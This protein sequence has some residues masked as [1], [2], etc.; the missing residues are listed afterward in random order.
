MRSRSPCTAG[1]HLP[2]A[3]SLYRLRA[4]ATGGMPGMV[5]T[6]GAA[7]VV[8]GTLGTPAGALGTPAGALACARTDCV[9]TPA[10]MAVSSTAAINASVVRLDTLVTGNARFM[11]LK[12]CLQPRRCAHG[13]PPPMPPRCAQRPGG[14]ARPKRAAG[15]HRR[16]APPAATAAAPA[17]HRRP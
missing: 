12:V 1:L 6:L 7:A 4:S 16:R 3:V 15:R 9:A 5:L 13:S 8:G 2:L 17:T 10:P 11:I 14:P